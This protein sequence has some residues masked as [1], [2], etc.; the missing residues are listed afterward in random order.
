MINA[1]ADK[2]FL[3]ELDLYRKKDI[4]AKIISLDINENPIEQIEG[5]ITGGTINIDGKSAVRRT[6]SLTIVAEEVN[7]NDYYWGL[8]TKFTVS[9]GIKNLINDEYPDIIWFNEGIFVITSFNSSYTTNSYTINIQG[10]DKMCLLNGTV[11]GILPASID[12]KQQLLRE[13]VYEPHDFGNIYEKNKYYTGI[14]GS[15]ILCQ[16]DNFDAEQIYYSKKYNT[17]SKY[18]LTEEEYVPN[19]YYIVNE[20][21]VIATEDYSDSETYYTMEITEETGSTLMVKA[22]INEDSYE[23]GVY[24]IDNTYSLATEEFLPFEQYY[25][26]D[27]NSNRYKPVVLTVD[28][29][30]PNTYYLDNTYKLAE[31]EYSDTT[32]YYIKQEY[33]IY[34]EEPMTQRKYQPNKYFIY[35]PDGYSYE[36][37]NEEYNENTFY[38]ERVLINEEHYEP[39]VVGLDEYNPGTYYLLDPVLETYYLAEGEYNPEYQYYIITPEYKYKKVSFLDNTNYTVHSYY[40]YDANNDKYVLSEEPFSPTQK[41]YDQV[42]YET[43][44][45]VPIETIVREAVHFYGQEPYHNI[46]IN[47]IDEYGLELMEYRGEDP[48]YIILKDG[49]IQN[50]VADGSQ[51]FCYP[52]GVD[53]VKFQQQ[54]NIMEGQLKGLDKLLETNGKIGGTIVTTDNYEG[55]KDQIIDK[56]LR[57]VTETQDLISIDDA[58]YMVYNTLLDDYTLE[59]TP[60][61]FADDQDYIAYTIVKIEYGDAAGYKITDLTYPE[62]LIS[63][64]GD[65]LVTI[66]DKIKNI[67]TNF[68]YFYD[69]DGRFIFQ[70]KK[71]YV[72]TSWN[73]II[74]RDNETYVDNTLMRSA[75][76]YNFDN[77][78]L[79]ISISNT[80]K[81]DQLKN[82]FSVWGQ[83]KGVGDAEIPI[84]GRLALDKKPTAYI[85]Y[86]TIKYHYSE[87]DDGSMEIKSNSLIVEELMETKF[88][89]QNR[90]FSLES[91]EYKEYQKEYNDVLEQYNYYLKHPDTEEY[92]D[93]DDIK[94]FLFTG[95]NH[96]EIIPTYYHNVMYGGVHY[97]DYYCDWRELI[98]QMAKD[99]Y[100][101]SQEEDFHARLR[102][103][104]PVLCADGSTGYERYYTEIYSFWRDIYNTEPE[105]DYGYSGG[106]YTTWYNYTK[107][108]GLVKQDGWQPKQNDYSNMKCDFYLP[109]IQLDNYITDAKNSLAKAEEKRQALED[110]FNYLRKFT[111]AE[112][113]ELDKLNNA[114]DELLAEKQALQLE[115]AQDIELNL[116]K[117][118]INDYKT[119]LD[120]SAAMKN[121]ELQTLQKNLE[122]I[123]INFGFREK[124]EV[125]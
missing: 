11:G 121:E 62:D 125:I 21:Y 112:E 23:P 75:S 115:K 8:S 28:T 10:Q 14:G 117:T 85:S 35:Q 4:Y 109:T 56:F 107:E 101:Y 122:T 45:D 30:E 83:R 95:P 55:F 66:L 93:I 13:T 116:I 65:S 99:Y 2:E 100:A 88:L 34:E 124:S 86:P 80:P 1:L 98:Y 19:Q 41:Y 87:N 53:S 120:T 48:I 46:V 25:M 79:I 69:I 50:I 58:D 29:Y 63:S 70:K 113:E 9:I 61:M 94:E 67:F 59:P 78:E 49:N 54:K 40:V 31:G 108:Y 42:I 44:E 71:D 38:Y 16:E 33:N 3:R 110:Y 74:T 27:T 106:A 57:S 6:C 89:V 76:S 123:L 84:Y 73:N 103:F 105:V 111:T 18:I 82:D 15:Y 32:I 52:L 39:Y 119:Y 22:N 47:D 97:I 60:V 114:K 51:V 36:P 64:L 12:F 26:K 24:Y 20:P 7:I 90:Y 17:Y 81:F 37:S 43:K 91:E 68:E 104:N 5:K 92:L 77:N 118:N 102:E 72:T 96:Y